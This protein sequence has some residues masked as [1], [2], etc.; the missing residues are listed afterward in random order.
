V[1]GF[2][3]VDKPAGWTS[4]DVVARV[5]RLTG[6]RRVGHAGTLDPLATGVLPVGLGQGTRVLEYVSSA[7]KAYHASLR[8]GIT[9]DTYDAEGRTTGSAPLGGLTASDIEQALRP[10]RGVFEQ[11]APLYSAIKQH[12]RPLY[13]YAR[14]GIAAEA[15]MRVVRVE[16]LRLSRWDSPDAELDIECASGFYVRSLAHDLGQALGCGAHLRALRRTRVGAFEV[17]EAVGLDFLAESIAGSRIGDCLWSLDAPLRDRPAVVLSNEHAAQLS[18]G[19]PWTPSARSG[20]ATA[21]VCRAYSADGELIA[22][23]ELLP[24]GSARPLKVFPP[25][26]RG[27]NGVEEYTPVVVIP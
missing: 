1:D 25:G 23:L 17:D 7:G 3:I 15:P 9:T 10:F 24:D 11:R 20:V 12:G 22:L 16:A 8:L 2:L 26:R 6:E 27:L 19:R 18:D 13:S 21:G 5:R 4:H 14:A